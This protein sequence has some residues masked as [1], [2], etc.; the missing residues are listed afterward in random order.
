MQQLLHTWYKN[1]KRDLPWRNVSNPYFIWL[2]EVILQQTRVAQGL[3]Y[4]LKFITTYPTIKNLALAPLDDILKL[5]QGL[6]YYSRARNMHLTAK[7]IYTKYGN[8]F[9][10]THSDL[11]AQKGIGTYTAAAIASFAYNMPYAVLDGNVYR[12]L[13]RLFLIDEEINTSKGKKIFEAL[14]NDFLDTKNP[15]THNQAL[16]ELGALV[17]LPKK[18]NCAVCPLQLYCLACKQ[19]VEN[20]Y[21]KKIKKQKP[22]DRYFNYIFI[23]HKNHTYITQRLDKDIWQNLY[24][25]PMIESNKDEDTSMVLTRLKSIVNADNTE[26]ILLKYSCKHQLTHQTIWANFFEIHVTKINMKTE[27]IKIPIDEIKKYAVPRLLEKFMIKHTL[28]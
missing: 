18:P 17:C 8:T 7:N 28:Q 20:E 11:L 3:P 12:V 10:T 24:E 26:N 2:S 23:R 22:R 1:N 25:F 5:W 6:G 13:S 21:P 27:W 15:S 9:P 19:N 16:M 14:S 4:Y